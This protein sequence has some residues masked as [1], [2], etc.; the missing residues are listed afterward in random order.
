ME[1]SVRSSCTAA[2]VWDDELEPTPHEPMVDIYSTAA[3]P[4]PAARIAVQSPVV[5]QQRLDCLA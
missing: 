4:F 2:D 5:L 3:A 1:R